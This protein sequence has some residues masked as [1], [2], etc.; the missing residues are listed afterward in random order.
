MDM[1]NDQMKA[2]R[3]ARW[4]NA[5]KLYAGIQAALA[6]GK[7]VQVATYTKATRYTAKHADLFVCKKDGV[8]VKRGKALD[9]ISGTKIQAFG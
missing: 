5:R 6:G 9:C 8:Y 2:N 7:M 3:F 4:N 1:T